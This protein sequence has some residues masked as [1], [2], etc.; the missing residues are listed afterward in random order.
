MQSWM[1][2]RFECE[3]VN[4]DITKTFKTSDDPSLTLKKAIKQMR[5]DGWSINANKY[6]CYC[7]S[8]KTTKYKP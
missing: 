2:H 6:T 5:K 8:C 7:P 3:G 1:T 4:C